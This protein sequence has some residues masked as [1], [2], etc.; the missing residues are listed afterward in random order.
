MLRLRVF[1]EGSWSSAGG[2]E[3]VRAFVVFGLLLGALGWATHHVTFEILTKQARAFRLV[4][5]ISEARR[6]AE[7]VT[8]I[9]RGPSGM[10]FNRVRRNKAALEG[11]LA[12]LLT[13]HPD[14]RFV[15]VRD[16]FGTPV[17]TVLAPTAPRGRGTVLARAP[18]KVA[19]VVEGEVRVGISSEA[20]DQDV[21]KLQRSL[22]VTVVIFAAAGFCLLAIGFIY[23]IHLIRK[24]R[25]L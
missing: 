24:N 10:D 3:T 25:A 21:A 14:L 7:V 16:R 15:D 2:A 13:S 6:A 9:G 18:L 4:R 12:D 8:S 20:F 5:G 23:V 22:F 1:R 19:G 17:A 11:I